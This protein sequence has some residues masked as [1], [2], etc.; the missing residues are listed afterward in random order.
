[1]VYKLPLFL[2]TLFILQCQPGKNQ[3]ANSNARGAAR[4]YGGNASAQD[5]SECSDDKH[6]QGY[7][8]LEGEDA[9]AIEPTSVA[10]A[11][12]AC[13]K[14][15][16]P[17]FLA[18]QI[19]TRTSQIRVPSTAQLD[20][21]V[22]SGSESLPTTAKVHDGLAAG[23]YFFVN[24]PA[25]NIASVSLNIK[26]GRASDT[27]SFALSSLPADDT[28]ITLAAMPV[29]TI[30][31]S[32]IE[33]SASF[34]LDQILGNGILSDENDGCLGQN[35]DNAASQTVSKDINYA[36][37]AGRVSFYADGI[38]GLQ[39]NNAYMTLK[40]EPPARQVLVKL[41]PNAKKLLM[42]KNLDFVPGPMSF[43]FGYLGNE[44]QDDVRLG[45]F[46]FVH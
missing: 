28:T 15:A 39:S 30:P 38:C 41:V 20:W 45:S 17:T 35:D 1:M 3:T 22:A 18:C 7:Q 12:L 37:D 5:I 6:C 19:Q 16:D 40:A 31:P 36:D 8:D 29:D 21:S 24:M 11:F 13:L 9:E 33:S 4:P 26:E 42:F 23:S 46:T 10:G 27:L 2:F 32:S 34:E 14:A 43:T 25:D 44:A